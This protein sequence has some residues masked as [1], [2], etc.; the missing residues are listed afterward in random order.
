ML[1]KKTLVLAI[2]AVAALFAVYLLIG[3]KPDAK[4]EQTQ[5]SESPS[6]NSITITEE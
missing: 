1:N 6:N 4:P 3:E 5:Q 2:V